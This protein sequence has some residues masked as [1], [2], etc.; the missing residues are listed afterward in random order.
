M[1]CV[2]VRGVRVRMRLRVCV[3]S[4]ECAAVSVRP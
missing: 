1:S 4:R 3:Y 2:R